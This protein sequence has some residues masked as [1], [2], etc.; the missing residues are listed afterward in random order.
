MQGLNTGLGTLSGGLGQ[1]NTSVQAQFPTAIQGITELNGGFMQLG[2]YNTSLL[3]GAEKLKGRVQ[4]W[5]PE[6]ER[7][8]AERTSLHPV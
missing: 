1:L 5:Q 4:H 3:S 7:C 2:S 6:Q 8:R